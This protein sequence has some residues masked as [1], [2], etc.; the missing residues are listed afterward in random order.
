MSSSLTL[1]AF[2]NHRQ[3]LFSIAYRMLGGWSEADDMV[4]EVWLR[5]QAQDAAAIQ[6]AKAWLGSAMRRLCIDQLRSARYQREK[7]YGIDTPDQLLEAT[8]ADAAS[9]VDRENSLAIAFTVILEAL[10]PTERAVF[11]LREVFDYDYA[12]TAAIVGKAEANC[13]QI[14]CRAKA[15]LL[16]YSPPPRQSTPQARHLVEKLASAGATGEVMELI[17]VVQERSTCGRADANGLDIHAHA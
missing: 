16:A 14:V 5:W 15:Q 17:E 7:N 9:P 3:L 6:S 11:L 2:N 1:D 10:K 8:T 4:Q 12:D 13:R